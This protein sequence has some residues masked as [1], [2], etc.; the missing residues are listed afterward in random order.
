M[1]HSSPGLLVPIAT[2]KIAGVRE[3]DYVRLIAGD[4][5]GRVRRR[6]FISLVGGATALPLAARG[7]QAGKVYRVGVIGI[8]TPV[9]DLTE[10]AIRA[11]VQGLR[12]LGYVEGQNL[13]LEFRSARGQLERLGDIVAE[14]VHLKADV[15]VT[16]GNP[17]ARAAKAVTTTVPIVALG[18][19]DPVGDGLVQ[20]LGRP[21]GNITGLTIRVG[22]EIEAKRLELLKEMLPGV[23]QVAYLG[24]KENQD[25]GAPWGKS[26]R[27]A[28]QAMGVALVLAEHTQG[29]YTDAFAVISRARAEA[30]FV[31][32]SPMAY[33]D[34][35]LI[36][37]F[38]TRTHMPCI[39]LW[40]EAVDLGGLMSYGVSVTD[41]FRRAANYVDKILKGSKPA[42][43]PV[44]QPIKFELIINLKTAK[45]LGLTVPPS[46][47]ARADEVIE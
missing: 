19:N 26:V 13:I 27:T 7:Q 39:F 29:Q 17:T 24:S 1:T 41:I 16:S 47:L 9:L 34:R 35:A 5:E 2:Q 31:G 44:E 32:P 37:G 21:G 38:A 33:G 22:P 18:V 30:L 11:F 15:I 4:E 14:L 42:D 40:R 46:L 23:S 6:E 20:S 8:A 25:W 28:A 43:L 3:G 12:V 36:V 10:P 45:A